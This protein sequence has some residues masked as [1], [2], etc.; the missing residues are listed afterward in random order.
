MWQSA[1]QA[2]LVWKQAGDDFLLFHRPSG[3]T[4]LFNA[5]SHRLLTQVS[6][7][8]VSTDAI[9]SAF[10]APAGQSHADAD[11]RAHWERL[12]QRLHQT[13]IASENSA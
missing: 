7:E 13:S 8:P 5:A 11:L 3:K 4:H 1:D 9:I 10:E 12:L 6:A 2:D